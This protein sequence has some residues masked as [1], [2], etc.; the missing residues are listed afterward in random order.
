MFPVK[1]NESPGQHSGKGKNSLHDF[2]DNRLQGGTKQCQERFR[3]NSSIICYAE[4]LEDF[5]PECGKPGTEPVH[6]GMVS[7]RLFEPIT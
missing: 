1:E 2:K 6:M 7:W 4:S 5:R 3:S